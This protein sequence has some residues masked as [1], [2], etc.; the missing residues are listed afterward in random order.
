MIAPNN[1][2]LSKLVELETQLHGET[3]VDLLQNMGLRKMKYYY[4][5]IQ[6]E[7]T[8]KENENIKHRHN[9]VASVPSF[10]ENKESFDKKHD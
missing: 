10:M 5:W 4:D 9:A 7:K 6:N 2:F 3:T 1:G 8:R